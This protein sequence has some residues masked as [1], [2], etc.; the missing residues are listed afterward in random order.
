M[1]PVVFALALSLAVIFIVLYALEASKTCDDRVSI[2]EN[3]VREGLNHDDETNHNAMNDDVTNNDPQSQVTA[4]APVSPNVSSLGSV[5]SLDRLSSSSTERFLVA[6]PAPIPQNNDRFGSVIDVCGDRVLVV[7]PHPGSVHM[8]KNNVRT[9]VIDHPGVFDA[10]FY[11]KE[12]NEAMM[13]CVSDTTVQSPQWVFETPEGTRGIVCTKDH[14]VLYGA[15]GARAYNE[16]GQF[17]GVVSDVPVDNARILGESLYLSDGTNKSYAYS[18]ARA[19]SRDVSKPEL[20]SFVDACV[21]NGVIYVAHDV[22]VSIYDFR[23]GAWMDQIDTSS[24]DGRHNTYKVASVCAKDGIIYVGVP[25]DRCVLVY[26]MCVPD[27]AAYAE[28]VISAQV[29]DFGR[30]VRASGDEHILI[31]APKVC[32]VII[33]ESKFT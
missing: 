27:R 10:V 12:G 3:V 24:F 5:A 33:R 9:G 18:Y 17:D 23:T 25:D 7:Q 15:Y 1:W 4:P 32:E 8:Y 19:W 21:D 31:G 29:T 30:V 20:P 26:K 28:G 6:V 14:I 16:S 11:Q 2:A 22:F 13:V